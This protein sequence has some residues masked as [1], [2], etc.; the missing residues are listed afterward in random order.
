MNLIWAMEKKLINLYVEGNSRRYE[1]KFSQ[2]EVWW[3]NIIDILYFSRAR[4]LG[5]SPTV[6]YWVVLG[7]VDKAK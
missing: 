4:S 5:D 6:S 2:H 3:I 7:V 1:N